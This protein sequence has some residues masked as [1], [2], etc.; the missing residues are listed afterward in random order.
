MPDKLVL[1]P[2]AEGYTYL[3]PEADVIRVAVDGGP[4]RYRRDMEGNTRQVS[5]TWKVNPYGY[6]YLQK[7][8]R[9]R[10]AAG[11]LPF[12]CDL[13]GEEGEGPQEHVCSFIPGTFGLTAQSGMLYVVAATLEVTPLQPEAEYDE[14]YMAAYEET[15]GEVEEFLAALE[16]AVN[17]K[18]PS[19]SDAV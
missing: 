7:F 3:E 15:A 4:G 16:Y 2:E 11:S 19:I 18:F 17:I 8:Y 1:V 12:L 5:V 10:L 6:A 9:T 14:T 13:V